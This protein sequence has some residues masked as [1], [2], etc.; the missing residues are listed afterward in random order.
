MIKAWLYVYRMTFPHAAKAIYIG[1]RPENQNSNVWKNVKSPLY[2]ELYKEI[3]GNRDRRTM[4]RE[5]T[6]KTQGH[7]LKE[8]L[9]LT[10]F[11]YRESVFYGL[12]KIHMS[13]T[14]GEAI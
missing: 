1:T 12:P 6:T 3:P 5:S 4:K 11:D 7:I 10:F 9:F 13:K 8:T 2:G 14:I